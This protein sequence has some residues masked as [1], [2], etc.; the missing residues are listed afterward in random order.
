MKFFEFK[1]YSPI[2]LTPRDAT[3]RKLFWNFKVIEMKTT[4]MIYTI[5]QL[6]VWIFNMMN[7]VVS[8]SKPTLINFLIGTIAL[9]TMIIVFI[10]SIKWSE[11]FVYL[12]PIH[13]LLLSGIFLVVLPDL[14]TGAEECSFEN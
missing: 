14:R 1:N 13:R 7:L 12:L 10:I 11:A 9:V 4:V 2:T 5:F 3:D 8:P 6:A